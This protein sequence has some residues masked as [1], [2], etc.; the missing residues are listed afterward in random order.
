MP[1]QSEQLTAADI[2]RLAEVTRATVSN[3]RRRHPDFPQPSGGTAASPTYDRGAVEAWLAAR[4]QLPER[5]AEDD[6]RAELSRPRG[7]TPPHRLYPVVV[8]ASRMS[9]GELEILLKVSDTALAE[10]LTTIAA[11]FTVDPPGD[12]RTPFTA[13]DAGRLRTVLDYVREAGAPAALDLLSERQGT[14]PGVRG[15]FSTPQWAAELMADVAIRDDSVPETVLDPACGTGGLLAVAARRGATAFLGQD[16]AV[17]QA[18]LAAARIAVT[19]PDA[20]TAEIRAATACG[21]TRSP[22]SRPTSSCATHRSRLATGDTTR[23]RSTTGGSMA[24]RPRASR[25]SRGCSTA[26]HT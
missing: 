5:S 13:D 22:A 25:N 21:T 14:A 24:C 10:G 11:P 7:V 6:V 2:S 8:A 15:T 12:E 26:S 9:P 20:A 3:W 17:P 16:I 4:G 23:S 19:A 1:P 18:A